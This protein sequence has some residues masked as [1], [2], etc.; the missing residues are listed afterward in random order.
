MPGGTLSEKVVRLLPLTRMLLVIIRRIFGHFFNFHFKMCWKEHPRFV[1][2]QGFIL[3][4]LF[5]DYTNDIAELFSLSQV[6]VL[7][8]VLMIV[9]LF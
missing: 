6:F 7:L 8:S 9:V 1:L 2:G 3:A 5:A 4:L